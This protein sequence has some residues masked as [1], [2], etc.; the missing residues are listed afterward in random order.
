MSRPVD[1]VDIK[2]KAESFYKKAIVLK[3]EETYI[4]AIA[5]VRKVREEKKRLEEQSGR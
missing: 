5:G 4:H 2:L 3:G 1:V